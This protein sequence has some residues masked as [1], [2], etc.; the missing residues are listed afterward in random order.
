M[1]D[2][3]KYSNNCDQHSEL[4]WLEKVVK[5]M[6]EYHEGKNDESNKDEIEVN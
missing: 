1:K 2:I 6:Q 4:K 5:D 3:V